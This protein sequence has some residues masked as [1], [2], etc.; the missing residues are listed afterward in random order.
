MPSVHYAVPYG[1]GT[2]DDT[3]PGTEPRPEQGGPVMNLEDWRTTRMVQGWLDISDERSGLTIA[4]NC[5]VFRMQEGTVRCLIQLMSRRIQ[6]P[7]QCR[8]RLIPHDGDWRS[9]QAHQSAESLLMPLAAYT[10]SDSVS[11]K[12]E[13]PSQSFLAVEPASVAVTAVKRAEDG[14]GLIVRL[15]EMSGEQATAR[16]TTG[17]AVREAYACDLMEKDLAPVRLDAL[18]F[19]PCE[20]VT[21]RLV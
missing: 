11:P 12:D 3:M 2:L 17:F 1:A 21:L 9:A 13:R 10:V 19:A 6:E 7:L 16:L 8:L 14:N 18:A 20:I 15:V 4:S 5:R